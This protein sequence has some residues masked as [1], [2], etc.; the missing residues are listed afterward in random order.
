M[1]TSDDAEFSE[2]WRRDG[3]RVAA[4]VRRH[5]PP[6][7]VQDVVAE[8]FVQ[9]WRRWDDVPRPPI[10]WLI[11]A[12]RRVVG[13]SRRSTRRRTALHDRLRLLDAAA[14]T[15]EDA[16]LLATDRMAALEAL[17]ALPDDQREALLLVAWDGLTPDAA[18]DVLGIRPGTF[19]VRAHRARA[20]LHDLTS[21]AEPRTARPHRPLTEGGLR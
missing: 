7:D 13:N 6:D 20:A 1:S 10:A 11:A 19:R 4:Y 14:R 15:G 8:T 12:A 16:G 3:P 5:V 9:A 2:A 17:A 21:P 18:A